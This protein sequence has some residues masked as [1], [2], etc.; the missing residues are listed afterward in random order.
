MYLFFPS[1]LFPE[2]DTPEWQD[3]RNQMATDEVL[4]Y[5]ISNFAMLD[6]QTDEIRTRIYERK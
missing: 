4:A 3:E 2:T 6:S 5:R 1:F